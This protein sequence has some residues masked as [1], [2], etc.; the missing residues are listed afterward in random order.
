[1]PT[2]A[3]DQPQRP[4]P[5]PGMV[6]AVCYDIWNLGRQRVMYQGSPQ[7]K[8]QVIIAFEVDE[9][10][11]DGNYA[12]KRFTI[13]RTFTAKVSDKAKVWPFLES[14]KGQKMSVDERKK[15]DFDS[16]VGT[17]CVI[18]IGHDVSKTTGKTY[19]NILSIGPLMKTMGKIEP[20]V[21][22]STPQWVRETQAKAIPL[23]GSAPVAVPEPV[24]AQ[25]S[26]VTGEEIPF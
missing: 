1:M 6:Q 13:Q 23:D 18:N 4:L 16:L 9:L 14:W 26:M 21:A 8:P 22:R 7:I 19:A 17:N 2:Y 10:M 20:Q 25:V 24:A 11:K 12:G 15:F 5:Q 3:E